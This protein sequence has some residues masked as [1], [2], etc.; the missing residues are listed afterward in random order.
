MGPRQ[1]QMIQINHKKKLRKKIGSG[2]KQKNIIPYITFHLPSSALISLLVYFFATVGFHILEMTA[3]KKIASVGFHF[4]D[5]Y[6]VV[7]E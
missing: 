5:I 6:W 3:I 2:K 4:F 1:L 7:K